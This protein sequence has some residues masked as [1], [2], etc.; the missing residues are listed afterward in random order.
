M[1]GPSSSLQFSF[2]L[3]A[4]LAGAMTLSQA[5]AAEVSTYAADGQDK[6]ATTHYE[7]NNVYS[8][9]SSNVSLADLQQLLNDSK[10]NAAELASLKETVN[11]QARL[12]DELKRSSGSTANSSDLSD[13]KRDISDT[14]NDVNWLKST[15][16]SL[17]S[18]VK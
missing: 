18:R 5:Q 15:V 11:A 13:I 8:V 9:R 1:A 12:I 17:N 4:L 14:K 2:Q 6:L 16:N 3:A 10:R 7:T